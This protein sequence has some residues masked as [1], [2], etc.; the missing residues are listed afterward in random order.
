MQKAARLNEKLAI[1]GSETARLQLPIRLRE[2]ADDA[3]G[4]NVVSR[5]SRF[6]ERHAN[7][8]AL[9]ADDLY[10][11]DIGH[12][13][14]LIVKLRANTSQHHVIVATTRKGQRQNWNVVD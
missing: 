12:F 9:T 4:R 1:A 3:C 6:V 14:D 13:L 7:L 2:R 5:H 8:A 10:F 11:G